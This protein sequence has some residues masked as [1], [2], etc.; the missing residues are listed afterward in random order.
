MLKVKKSIGKMGLELFIAFSNTIFLPQNE[1]CSK[2][3]AILPVNK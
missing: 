1:K 2:T 3:G